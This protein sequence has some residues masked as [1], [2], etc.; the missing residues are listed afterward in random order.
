MSYLFAPRCISLPFAFGTSQVHEHV[1]YHIISGAGH[2]FRDNAEAENYLKEFLVRE[3][4]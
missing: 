3:V 1:E 2:S 4:K